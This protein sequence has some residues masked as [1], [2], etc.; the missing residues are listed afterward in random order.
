VAERKLQQLS[1]C[2]LGAEANW[3]LARAYMASCDKGASTA[4]LNSGGRKKKQECGLAP[5]RS[6]H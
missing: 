1:W 6:G 2:A 4:Q 3:Q 5:S